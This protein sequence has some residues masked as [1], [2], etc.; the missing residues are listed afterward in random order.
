MDS[1]KV[2]D[3]YAY[4][5]GAAARRV[6]DQTDAYRPKGPFEPLSKSNRFLRLN[7]LFLPKD[8][9][10]K[11][12]N[13]YGMAEWQ[14]VFDA[15]YTAPGDYLLQKERTFFIAAQQPLLPVYC[16]EA[17]RTLTISRPSVQTGAAADPYGGY[18]STGNMTLMQG[19]PASVLAA[20]GKGEPAAHLPTDQIVPFL[21][22]LIPAIPFV[23]LS[24]G[25]MIS[26]DLGRSAVIT[27]SE[28]TALGW[29]LTAKLATT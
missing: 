15:S 9:S 8:G 13:G 7:A 1:S 5:L 27:V 4:G 19:W 22:I 12:A 29:R 2:Q 17:N 16:V 20:T 18:T 25:D 28:L 26:D 21:A 23:S 24:P 6:G 14:G 10:S 3:R 11:H